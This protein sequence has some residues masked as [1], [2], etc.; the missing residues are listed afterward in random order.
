MRGA[1]ITVEIEVTHPITRHAIF[2]AERSPG[3]GRQ[4]QRPAGFDLVAPESVVVWINELGK[5]FL[6]PDPPEDG[7][8]H[9][10]RSPDVLDVTE[11]RRATDRTIVGHD[12]DPGRHRPRR[13]PAPAAARCPSAGSFR[14]GTLTL[15]SH[16][17]LYLA[18][19]SLL[20]GSSDPI[21]YPIDP[22]RHESAADAA[23]LPDERYLGR[24][25]TFLAAAARRRR[26]RTCGSPV[27][28]RSTASGTYL[29]T[30]R[31]I[32]AESPARPP[33]P[34][35]IDRQR[36]P[37]PQRRR[38]GRSTCSAS[39]DVALS[40]TSRSINDRTNLNTDGIDPDMSSRR[41]DRSV[42][43]LHA[44]T[45]RSA[46][47]P[48]ATA[49]CPA[50]PSGIAVSNNL[51]SA[52]RRRAEGRAANR[53]RRASPTSP[54]SDNLVFDSGRAMSAGGPGRARPTS[55]SRPAGLGS[56]P[57]SITSSN[58]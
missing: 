7:P 11:P 32:G 5:L 24:T 44:R 20:Q 2:P 40:R 50:N 35:T 17:T 12:R 13:R 10:R 3:S 53:R 37:V 29:R 58:R 25:M 48:R 6:L 28:G 1:G 26:P 34:R 15:K 33:E 57:T 46:S 51:V 55:T 56:A 18:P 19:G 21:D 43:H 8:A 52:R 27:A 39:S 22:G 36:R 9:R 47:R 14:T 54:S 41:D 23:L 45:M 16:V 30:R 38:P 4:R 42:V 49:T 31:N